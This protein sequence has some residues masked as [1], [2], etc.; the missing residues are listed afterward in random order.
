MVC[1]LSAMSALLH[2]VFMHTLQLLS[3]RTVRVQVWVGKPWGQ[4]SLQ[5]V[6]CEN[7]G[8]RMISSR[9]PHVPPLAEK[10]LLFQRMMALSSLRPSPLPL[11]PI[12]VLWRRRGRQSWEMQWMY[13]G[14]AAVVPS[15]PPS[16]DSAD[17]ASVHPNP[18][19]WCAVDTK[20]IYFLKLLLEAGAGLLHRALPGVSRCLHSLSLLKQQHQVT[21]VQNLLRAN[22][23]LCPPSE[24]MRLQKPLQEAR[25]LDEPRWATLPWAVPEFPNVTALFR[26][27]IIQKDTG[28]AL[29]S[30]PL[31]TSYVL[32]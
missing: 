32:M 25:W 7:S 18:S 2:L 31:P 15:T 19:R 6:C 20:A 8:H 13:R 11:H 4:P 1:Y 14:G 16:L 28:K 30:Q 24:D 12:A 21:P 29:C 22:T 3:V 17:G 9:S 23:G 5:L 27:N 26:W 10:G